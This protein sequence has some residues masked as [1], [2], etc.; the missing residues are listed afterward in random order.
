MGVGADPTN[1]PVQIISFTVQVTTQQGRVLEYDA[2]Q[3]VVGG[4][5]LMTKVHGEQLAIGGTDLLTRYTGHRN[6]LHD[7]V[8][9][10][11]SIGLSA[12]VHRG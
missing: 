12:C 1:Y 10:V 2:Y 5:R 6:R 4:Y 11:E 8:R 9:F 3:M 7:G